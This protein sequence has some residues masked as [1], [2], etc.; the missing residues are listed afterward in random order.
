MLKRPMR[1]FLRLPVIVQ[2]LA[3]ASVLGGP[4]AA[5]AERVTLAQAYDRMLRDGIELGMI[6]A[7]LLASGELVQQAKGQRR[8][9]VD[10]TLQYEQIQ[11]DV[12]SSDNTAYATGKSDYPKMS[13]R[14]TL[15][16]PIYDAVRFRALPLA[17]AE[18]AVR[19]AEAEIAR[20]RV[21]RDLIIS[22]LDV[23]RGQLALDRASVIVKGRSEYERSLE[24]EVDAGRVELDQLIRAQGDTMAAESDRMG[25]EIGMIEALGDLQRFAGPD[26]TGVVIDGAQIGIASMGNLDRAMGIEQVLAMSPDLAA[27]KAALDVA[28]R[29]KISAKGAM[30]PS[31]DLVLDFESQKTEGSLFGGGSETQ[32]FSGGVMMTVPIYEGGI[33]KSRVREAD[34]GIKSAELKVKQTEKLLRGRHS[35]LMGAAKSA[36]NRTGKVARQLS[37]AEQSLRAAQEQFD[38]GRSSQAVLLEMRLRRDALR[39]DVQMARLQELQVQAELYAL[40]GA[41]DMKS[42]SRQ[43]GG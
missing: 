18:D 33:K 11:Q 8:P 30:Q 19:Q 35:A 36:A 5:L 27:A 21:A 40:F 17:K 2:S 31:V 23:A 22:Y 34:A 4:T 3:L 15:R 24:E 1:A 32:T 14:L 20:N 7:D 9:R 16:Q 38:V 26:V 28:E 39:I 37:L 6:D 13:M 42:I 29:R 43:A 10:I 25:A 41:F 12:L